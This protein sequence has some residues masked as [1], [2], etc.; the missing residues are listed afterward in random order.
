MGASNHH[1]FF[2]VSLREIPLKN[3]QDMENEIIPCL[4]FIKINLFIKPISIYVDSVLEI[5]YNLK[6]SVYINIIE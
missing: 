2:V 1:L 5:R 4:F 6:Y 3:K